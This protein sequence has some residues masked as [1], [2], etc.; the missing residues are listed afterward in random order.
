MVPDDDSF[1]GVRAVDHTYCV[2]DVRIR[3]LHVVAHA[4][5]DTR[6]RSSA[7]ISVQAAD[8]VLPADFFAGRTIPVQSSQ[9]RLGIQERDGYRRNLRRHIVDASTGDVFA[10]TWISRC[11]RVSWIRAQELDRASLH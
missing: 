2:P 6:S 10:D 11:S 1:I 5:R 9:Y 8:P 7:V 3:A 4:D